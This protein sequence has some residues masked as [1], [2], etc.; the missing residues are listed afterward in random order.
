MPHVVR[1]LCTGDVGR[2]LLMATRIR[3]R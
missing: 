3:V 2:M 1:F